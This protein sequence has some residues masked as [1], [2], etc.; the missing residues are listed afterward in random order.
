MNLVPVKTGFTLA[1]KTNKHK[2]ALFTLF[3]YNTLTC[4]IQELWSNLLDHTHTGS[5]I[6]AD[7]QIDPYAC[8]HAEIHTHTVLK[9]KESALNG[10]VHKKTR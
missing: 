3:K 1:F 5:H 6:P 10:S 9:Q 4:N 8:S 2:K 7:T